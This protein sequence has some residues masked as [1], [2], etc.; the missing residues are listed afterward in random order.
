M[1]FTIQVKQLCHHQV[2]Y[3]FINSSAQE[4]DPFLQEQAVNIIRAT[5]GA[6]NYC[7]YDRHCYWNMEVMV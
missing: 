1:I 5:R 4:N 7:W 2:G 3:M 6:V